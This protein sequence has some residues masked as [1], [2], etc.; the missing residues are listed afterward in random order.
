[1][2]TISGI[3]EKEKFDADRIQVPSTGVHS[4]P[5]QNVRRPNARRRRAPSKEVQG[6]SAKNECDYAADESRTCQHLSYKQSLKDVHLPSALEPSRFDDDIAVRV[7]WDLILVQSDGEHRIMTRIS[8]KQ[9]TTG[10]N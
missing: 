3:W 8:T 6:L 9:L 10:D 5:A 1:M 4:Y 2:G 7:I